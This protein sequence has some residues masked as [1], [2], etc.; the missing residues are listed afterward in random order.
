MT[1]P[2]L[3]YKRVDHNPTQPNPLPTSRQDTFFT[4]TQNQ[5]LHNY[6]LT[7]V[8]STYMM[9]NINIEREGPPKWIVRLSWFEFRLR[10]LCLDHSSTPTS[11][12]VSFWREACHVSTPANLFNYNGVAHSAGP[13]IRL[14]AMIEKFHVQTFRHLMNEWRLSIL[15]VL[16]ISLLLLNPFLG[17]CVYL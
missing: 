12:V 1:Q 9:P 3:L 13:R 6:K 4:V 7:I 10:H 14:V 2:N 15:D 16:R 5:L 17:R 8:C 11:M